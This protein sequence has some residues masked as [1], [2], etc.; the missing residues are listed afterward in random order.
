MSSNKN[1]DTSQNPDNPDTTPETSNNN[2]ISKQ[3][4]KIQVIGD[5][6]NTVNIWSYGIGHFMND[7]CASTWF[8]YFSYYLIQI[9][10]LNKDYATY[11]VLSGQIFDALATPLVGI[12]SDKTNTRYGKRSPW[13]FFGTLLVTLTF[14]LIF[15]SAMPKGSSEFENMIYYSTCASIFNVGWATVQVAHMAL[16]PLITLSK[17]KKDKMTRIRTG[18]TFIAQTLTLALSFVYFALVRN[19]I[20]QYQL[21]TGTSI[22][23]GLILS[24]IFMCLCREH[25]LSKNIN[26][27][28]ENIKVALKKESSIS[29]E[30]LIKDEEEEKKDNDITWVYWLQKSDFYFYILVYMFIRLSINIT[31]TMLPFYM[32]IVL[33]YSLTEDGG[34]PYQITICLLLST[35]GSIFNSLFL[36]KIIEKNSSRKY[37]RITLLIIALIFVAIGCLPLY[38]LTKELRWPL[39]ILAFIWGMGFSQALSCVSSLTNDVVGSKGA[40]GAFVYGAFSF[41]D[42]LSCGIFLKFFL[43]VACDNYD[44]LFYTVIFFPPTTI[45][46]GIIF[47]WLRM[48]LKEKKDK[49]YLRMQNEESDGEQMKNPQKNILDHSRL[50]FV[51]NYNRKESI[52]VTID[53]E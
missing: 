20:L 40:K 2:Q 47:V 18:F 13:Y 6:L 26:K 10:K 36:E 4:K 35:I 30:F 3:D 43:P 28:Y 24:T 33:G 38:F 7:M 17:K 32:E 14:T 53:K 51:T 39:F 48:C 31:S 9:V 46:F 44:I 8:F 52:N 12:F 34:T 21:L 11:V 27:Y 50:T 42:K 5:D 16:L 41:A 23:L 25:V 1:Y 19:K 45:I 22:G 37:Q 15:F 29:Q 49:N